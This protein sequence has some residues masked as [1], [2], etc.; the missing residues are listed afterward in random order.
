MSHLILVFYFKNKIIV[1][2]QSF[3]ILKKH[4]FEK[5]RV[6]NDKC[7]SLFLRVADDDFVDLSLK[8]RV[9]FTF[10]SPLEVDS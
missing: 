4:P 10:W 5:L 1:L 8:I 9:S 2:S 6:C 3:N 7:F